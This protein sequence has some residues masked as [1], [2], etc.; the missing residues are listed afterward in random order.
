M[1]TEGLGVNGT[2]VNLALVLLS[3]GLESLVQLLA[4]LGGLGEDVG[5][6]EASR[7]VVS[8]GLGANL[9]NQ[10]SGGRLGELLD[11]IGI[12]LLAGED[13]LALVEGLVDDNGGG[14]DALSLSDSGI[15]DTTEE[16]V[17]AQL[18][19]NGGEGLRGGLIVGV[20]VGDN[21]NVVGSLELLEG[22]LVEAGDSG[23]GLLHHV[24]GDGSSL[25]L[26][27]VGG[28]VVKALEDLEGGVALNAVIL[29]EVSL[30]SAV[31]LGELDVLLLEGGGSLLVLGCEGLAVTAPGGED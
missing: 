6:G 5:E 17:V 27:T 24:G 21:D 20:G 10:R 28:D 23:K 9:A 14:L 19:G 11:S 22:V 18:L 7:H 3:D 12:K 29:A 4:L 25:A 1:G 30:L 13:G 31:D 2:E 8:V 16:V 15:S 26:A